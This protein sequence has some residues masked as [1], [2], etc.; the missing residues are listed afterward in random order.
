MIVPSRRKL[1]G[2]SVTLAVGG[3][4][5]VVSSPANPDAALI[6][7]P[8]DYARL[9]AEYGT[10]CEAE[11]DLSEG[12]EMD[13]LGAR[14]DAIGKAMDAAEDKLCAMPARTLDGLRAKAKVLSN[15][16]SVGDVPLVDSLMRDLLG[17]V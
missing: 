1:L 7:A 13:A 8:L 10:V 9:W 12:P 15:R 14:L 17:R 6:A 16:M 4:A 5:P 2:A 3:T 11:D